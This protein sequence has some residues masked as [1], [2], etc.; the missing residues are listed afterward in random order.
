MFTHGLDLELTV[1]LSP[2]YFSAFRILPIIPH[3][4]PHFSIPHF[5]FRILHSAIPHFT[6]D[7]S[8]TNYECDRSKEF[9]VGATCRRSNDISRSTT[10]T[11]IG[12]GLFIWRRAGGICYLPQNREIYF[13]AQISCKFGHVVNISGKCVKFRQCVNFSYI[14]F[15]TK[16]TP[17]SK[18]TELL[19]YAAHADKYTHQT[20]KNHVTCVTSSAPRTISR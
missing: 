4:F 1:G 17:P 2:L 14:Y 16:M 6:N 11:I 18:L 3:P 12:I 7:R 15:R 9:K 20:L 8:A 19:A 13:F 10:R 5:T